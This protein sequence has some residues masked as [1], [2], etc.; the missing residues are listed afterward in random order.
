MIKSN[1]KRKI[2][3]REVLK[4]EKEEKEEKVLEG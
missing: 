4:E 3:I 1:V 2:K